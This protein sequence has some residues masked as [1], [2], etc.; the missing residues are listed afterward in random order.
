MDLTGGLFGRYQCLNGHSW[1]SIDA[2]ETYK[3]CRKC[4]E[5]A[6]RIESRPLKYSVSQPIHC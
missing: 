1:I 5:E 2:S 3:I 6:E 4:D